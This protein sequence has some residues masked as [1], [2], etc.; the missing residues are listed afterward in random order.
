MAAIAV[1]TGASGGLGQALARELRQ[2]GW[3][4]ALVGRDR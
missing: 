3:T 2:E 1:V 4:V